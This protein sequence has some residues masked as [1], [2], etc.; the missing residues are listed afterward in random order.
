MLNIYYNNGL[1]LFI[2][3]Q[4]FHLNNAIFLSLD[5]SDLLYFS[6][7]AFFYVMRKEMVKESICKYR[8]LIYLALAI[9]IL[10][11]WL[12]LKFYF[13]PPPNVSTVLSLSCL[14]F[15]YYYISDE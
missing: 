7:L 12:S 1:Y 9:I 14:N 6:I 10:G 3:I 13:N 15:L 8:H 5:L 2:L 4:I 11:R